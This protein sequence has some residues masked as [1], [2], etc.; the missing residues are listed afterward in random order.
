[1]IF[2][3]ISDIHGHGEA[4]SQCLI[5]LNDLG[6]KK[7]LCLGDIVDGGTEDTECI[8]ILRNCGIECV[9]GNHDEYNSLNL[10]DNDVAWLNAL[11]LTI[12]FQGWHM[13]HDSPRQSNRKIKDKYEAW[14]CFD[15]TDHKKILVGHSHVP[16][17]YE[18]KMNEGKTSN[19]VI[20]YEHDCVMKSEY[21]YIVSVPSLAY[22]R[23][24]DSRPAFCIIDEKSVAFSY[25]DIK[26]LR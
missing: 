3:V 26:P 10:S 7:V 16:A 1:M 20:V 4:L 12:D 6:I 13:V 23:S 21:R 8:A 19:N 5:L 22:N 24:T 2:A 11:P 25:L 9:R 17:I 14:N 15:E 18:Y